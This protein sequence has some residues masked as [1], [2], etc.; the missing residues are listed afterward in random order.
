MVYDIK[1]AHYAIPNIVQ[2]D[3]K[4]NWTKLFYAEV[5]FYT[6]FTKF[7]IEILV[8]FQAEIFILIVH[9]HGI[10]AQSF[11]LE[12]VPSQGNKR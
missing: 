1:I 6:K 7:S 4:K 8:F 5:D 12:E 10:F 2:H 9:H 11:R 3:K